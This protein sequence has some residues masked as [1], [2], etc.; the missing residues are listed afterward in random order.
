MTSVA[1]MVEPTGVLARIEMMI[2]ARA[3]IMLSTAANSVTERNER[4]RRIAA[5]AGKMISAEISREP[6][7]FMASTMMTAVI[8]AITRLMAST[9]VPVAREKV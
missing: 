6:T 5:R 4:N 7:R 9:A 3:Q 1:T 8:T 2:P